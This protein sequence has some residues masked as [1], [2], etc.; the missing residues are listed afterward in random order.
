MYRSGDLADENR[1]AILAT[2][3]YFGSWRI[4]SM[5]GKVRT[6]EMLLHRCKTKNVVLAGRTDLRLHFIISAALEIASR[7]RYCTCNWR[8]LRNFLMRNVEEVVSASSILLQ[9]VLA[10]SLLK[11]LQIPELQGEYKIAWR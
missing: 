4:E 7:K 1:A 9:I 8:N 11:R 6:D 2:A 5:I 3:I 10:L